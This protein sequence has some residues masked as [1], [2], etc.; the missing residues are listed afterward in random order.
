G[1]AEPGGVP[2]IAME[3][4]HRLSKVIDLAFSLHLRVSDVMA[5]QGATKK[6]TRPTYREQVLLEFLNRAFPPGSARRINLDSLFQGGVRGMI[7]FEKEMRDLFQ[8]CMARVEDKMAKMGIRDHAGSSKEVELWLDYYV[9]HF[10]PLDNVVPRVIM[11]HLR[12]ARDAIETSLRP[13]G[14]VFMSIQR[15]DTLLEALKQAREVSYLPERILLLENVEFMPGLA[16]CI[17]NG[18]WGLLKKDTPEEHPTSLILDLTKVDQKQNV[19]NDLAFLT[20]EQVNDLARRLSGFF[21]YQPYNYMDIVHKKRKIT[22]VYVFLNVW[23]YGKV[24]VV[25]RDN[26]SVWYCDEWELKDMFLQALE[27]SKDMDKLIRNK[28]LV[29]SLLDFFAKKHIS[30]EE[31]EVLAWANPNSLIPDRSM[32]FN[33][34]LKDMTE[35]TGFMEVIL[36]AWLQ[37]E[38]KSDGQQAAS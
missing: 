27:L 1:F 9:Q 32:A 11:K 20:Q 6:T 35:G 14:W 23:R 15:K 4:R 37:R 17:L 3:E 30:L 26:L 5:A 31:T 21:G 19:H 12:V 29:D 25:Y 38:L 24:S 33:A 22:G 10:Q 18:Y 34:K 8:R 28:S 16:H 13:E 2:G 7:H 36:K